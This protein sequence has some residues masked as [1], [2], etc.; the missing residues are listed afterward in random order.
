MSTENKMVRLVGW[1]FL[2]II[3]LTWTFH[4]IF[5]SFFVHYLFNFSFI[6][7]F[8]FQSVRNDSYDHHAAI[9]FLLQ[10]R[11]AS[12]SSSRSSSLSPNRSQQQQQQQ[13]KQPPPPQQQQQQQQH[14]IRRRPSSIAEQGQTRIIA[15]NFLSLRDSSN[16]DPHHSIT[17]QQL[18][19]QQQQQYLATQQQMPQVNLQW[20]SPA[21]TKVEDSCYQTSSG[22]KATDF[23]CLTCGC[24][25]LENTTSTTTC[26]KCARLRIRRRNFAHQVP[27]Q[28]RQM[29]FQQQLIQQQQLLQQQQQQQHLEMLATKAASE[30][31]ERG[32][33]GRHDSRDSGVSSGSSQVHLLFTDLINRQR[34]KDP[35]K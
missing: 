1:G 9:Y 21:A 34:K 13:Q 2:K 7:S 4:P 25:I 33:H 20:Q 15:E 17:S 12:S 23:N 8:N 35:S 11:L 18:Q 10:D 14:T 26:V 32:T 27:E 16:V 5:Y 28:G 24:S 6:F 30:E 19:Q 31:S 3:K 22:M 29:Q